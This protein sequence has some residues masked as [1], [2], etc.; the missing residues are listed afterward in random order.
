MAINLLPGRGR[1]MKLAAEPDGFIGALVGHL[2]HRAHRALLTELR[3]QA[4]FDPAKIIFNK[5]PG[6]NA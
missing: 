5:I 1:E 4:Q 2:R 6:G 3:E